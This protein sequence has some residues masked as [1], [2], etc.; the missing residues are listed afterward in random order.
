M[1]REQFYQ[2]CVDLFDW[3]QKR[4][5]INDARS[6]HVKYDLPGGGHLY[7]EVKRPGNGR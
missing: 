6:V 3:M 1:E 5:E 7:F 2:A 4:A